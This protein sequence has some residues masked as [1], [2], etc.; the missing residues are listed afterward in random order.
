[1]IDVEIWVFSGDSCALEPTVGKVCVPDSVDCGLW[2][3]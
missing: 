1:M 2:N 3:Y